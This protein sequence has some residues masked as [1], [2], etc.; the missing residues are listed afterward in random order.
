M[1]ETSGVDEALWLKSR[2]VL[3]VRIEFDP[4]QGLQR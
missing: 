1:S 3:A 2:Y 4:P